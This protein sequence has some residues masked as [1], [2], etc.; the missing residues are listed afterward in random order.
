M[1]E[2]KSTQ[3]L[4]PDIELDTLIA[5]REVTCQGTGDQLAGMAQIAA[6]S[7]VSARKERLRKA[8]RRTR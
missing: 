6:R 2:A 1:E 5:C 8:V 7:E 3:L 4:A